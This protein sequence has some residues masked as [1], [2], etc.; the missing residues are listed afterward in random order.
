[1]RTI[2]KVVGCILLACVWLVL[3]E[4]VNVQTI[5]LGFV[6]SIF[7]VWLS[8]RLLGIDYAE[9]F[10]LSPLSSLKYA[11][12]LIKEVYA[13][14]IMATI[15]ILR[16][17]IAPCIVQITMDT[18]IKHPFLQSIVANSITLTPGTITIDQKNG[19]LTVLCLISAYGEAPSEKFENL[20]IPMKKEV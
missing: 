18:R 1:M 10:S 16:G 13:A 20:V 6:L 12:I 11:I 7:C 9:T 15:D 2:R 8:G 17:N 14:G 3:N 19:E 5:A 4:T